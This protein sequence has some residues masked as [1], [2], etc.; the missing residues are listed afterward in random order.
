MFDAAELTAFITIAEAGTVR[1]AAEQLGVSQP[2]V[3]RRLQ[4]L[5]E[6]LGVKLFIRNAQRLRLSEA[7]TRLLPQARTHVDGLDRALGAIRDGARYATASVTV[8]CLATLSVEILPAILADYAR[9]RPQVRLRVLDLSARE[10]EESVRN[11]HADFAL[12]MLGIAEPALSQ[13]FVAEEPMV[14]LASTHHPLAVRER[15]R[16]SELA[17]VPLIAIGPQSA[18][19]RLLEDVQASLGVTL[20]WRHEVQRLS[21]AVELVAAGMGLTVLPQLAA[22]ASRRGDVRMVT[23]LEPQVMRRLG[24]LRRSG[25]ELSPAADA[26]RRAFATEL[27]LRLPRLVP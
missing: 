5:E 4:R 10:I 16:W 13:E 26:L 21:T 19:R 25:E 6:S 7:G 2:A 1:A 24:V 17:G 15:A 9:R 22:A 8:A 11:G 20:E 23:L 3:S 27:R 12:T 14:L 18:N